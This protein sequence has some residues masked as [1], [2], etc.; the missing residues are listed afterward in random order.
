MVTP[1]SVTFG[2]SV[3]ADEASR[4]DDSSNNSWADVGSS[5]SGSGHIP[6]V[7]PYF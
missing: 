5:S 2:A 6:E 4:C 7:V 3:E 1:I